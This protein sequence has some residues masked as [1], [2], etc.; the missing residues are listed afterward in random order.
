MTIEQDKKEIFD[1]VR[2]RR[3]RLKEIHRKLQSI[4]NQ[5]AIA[6]YNTI[7]NN[8]G[9]NEVAEDEWRNSK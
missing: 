7:M 4:E 2:K 5:R 3:L 9:E 6:V 8:D 1:E